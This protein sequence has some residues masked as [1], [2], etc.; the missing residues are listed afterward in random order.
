[1]T[2]FRKLLPAGLV[3]FLLLTGCELADVIEV[4]VSGP[5]CGR[6][7]LPPELDERGLNLFGDTPEPVPLDETIAELESYK[8]SH[9]PDILFA[10]GYSYIRKAATLSDDPAYYRRG[11]RLLAWAALCGQPLAAFFLGSIYDEGLEGV[12]KDP[13]LGACLIRLH[14]LNNYERRSFERGPISG[15]VWGCG[16]RLENVPE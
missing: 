2:H 1:M 5:H 6:F 11:V 4:A 7:G 10:L 3:A 12:D 16:L 15:R 9:G 8:N 13:E 14:D